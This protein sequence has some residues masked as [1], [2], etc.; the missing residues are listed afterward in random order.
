MLAGYEF[1]T[2]E[3]YGYGLISLAAG[4]LSISGYGLQKITVVHSSYLH[5][6]GETLR[7]RAL[8]DLM[9]ASGCALPALTFAPLLWRRRQLLWGALVAAVLAWT[10]WRI[11]NHMG[12]IYKYS[13]QIFFLAAGGISLVALAIADFL[14][15]RD[16]GSLLLGLWVFGTMAFAIL[17]NWD[18]NA[19][20][21][22]PMVP[23][24]GILIARRLQQCELAL[25]SWRW[26]DFTTAVIVSAAVS[27]W[28]AAGD[29]ALANTSREAAN[30]IHEKTKG[31]PATVWF[32][33]RWG[34]EYYMLEFGARPVERDV[35]QCKFGDFIVIP[36]YNTALF[37]FPL[38]TT[39]AEIVD[40]P[41]H[42]WVTAMNPDAGAGFYFSGWGP[43][44]FVFGAVPPQRYLMARVLQNGP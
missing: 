32:E 30:Y 10:F 21:M 11:W 2:R 37:K 12:S 29:A 38:N 5:G 43:L 8:A 20:S 14:K 41:V 16:A 3:L 28:V 7:G 23:A 15:K 33:G 36:K 35:D 31:E 27:L 34:F 17:V 13:P 19:R 4:H 22:L 9:F 25:G 40:F 6:R 39:R 24:A 44:P 42:T 1:Y 18:V 26:T